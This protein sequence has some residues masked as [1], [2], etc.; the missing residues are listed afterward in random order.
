MTKASDGAPR[1]KQSA[2]RFHNCSWDNL[3]LMK[4]TNV[5]RRFEL[6]PL[7]T[8]KNAWILEDD[9]FSEYRYGTNPVAS[10]QSLDR[11]ERVIY[12][13]NFSKSIVPFLRIGF[14]IAPP[15]I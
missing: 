11:N 3:W 9:Y 4:T 12:I 5:S 14:L 6:L 15:T 13:G 10:L 7:A 1:Q 2:Y 8:E